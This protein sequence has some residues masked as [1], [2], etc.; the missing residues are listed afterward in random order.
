VTAGLLLAT[1]TR[2]CSC[3]SA[4]INS[5]AAACILGG[6]RDR[7]GSAPFARSDQ[8]TYL[9]VRQRELPRNS[10]LT[11]VSPGLPLYLVAHATGSEVPSSQ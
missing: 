11:Q 10:G 3:W 2:P 9:S 4:D 1:H 6:A 8:V 7:I 5:T